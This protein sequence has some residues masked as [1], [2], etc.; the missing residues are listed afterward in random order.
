MTAR[1]CG[2]GQPL[3]NPRCSESSPDPEGVLFGKTKQ[4]GQGT[5]TLAIDTTGQFGSIALLEDRQ[6][7]EEVL[8]HS[9]DGFAH[10]LFPRISSLL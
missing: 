10:L 8:L 6:V 2:A 9:P 1:F 3:A 7:V 4:H 5:R